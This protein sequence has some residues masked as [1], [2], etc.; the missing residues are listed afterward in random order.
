MA[1]ARQERPL[2][3]IVVVGY[4]DKAVTSECLRSLESLDYRPLNVIYVD[5]DSPDGSLEH[6]RAVFPNVIAMPSGGNLGYCG[7]NNVGIAL[8]LDG[9]AEFVLILNPDTIVCNPSFIATLIDYMLANPTVGKVGPLVYLRKYGV[10]QNTILGWPSIAG[11][12]FSVLDKLVPA[13]QLP[14][15]QSVTTPTEVPSLNGCCL[16]IRADA[17]RDVGLYDAAFWCYMDEVDWDWQAEQAGWKRH[18]VPVESIVHLQKESGYDFASRANYFMKRNTAIWYAKTG[19]WLS[20]AAWIGIT[21]SIAV[22]RALFAP[23]LGRSPLKYA[24][25][26]FQLA[27]AY[28]VVVIDA[29]RG[30]FAR[31]ARSIVPIQSRA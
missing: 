16:L 21:L 3:S 8:A 23:L 11:S 7:G 12:L 19:K 4:N 9:G 6:V 26:T 20:L 10:V 2:V 29:V 25:F 14:K 24:R 28:A 1:G 17:L 22:A 15:S 31:P 30:K 5:N 18:Y 13:K 27:T